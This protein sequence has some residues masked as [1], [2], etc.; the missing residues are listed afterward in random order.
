[1]RVAHLAMHLI[2]RLVVPF[3]AA[4]LLTGLAQSLRDAVEIFRHYRLVAKLGLLVVA[5][6]ILLVHTQPV[7]QVRCC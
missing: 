4:S 3:S 7:G 1:M 6:A 2:T 5:T